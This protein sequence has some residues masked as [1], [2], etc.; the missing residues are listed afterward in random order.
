VR[1]AALPLLRE[2]TGTAARRILDVGTGVGTLLPD[3]RAAF[4]HAFIAGVDRSRGMLALA[5]AVFPRAV[6]DAT[7]LAIP[8][9]SVDLVLLVFMLFHLESPLEA[10][11]EARR[12]VRSGGMAG[13]VTWAS[14]LRSTA[15]RIWKACLDAHGAAPADPA[16]QERH[17]PVNTPGKMQALFQRA[18]FSSV[19]AWSEEFAAPIDLEHLIGLITTMGASK[20]RLDSLGP[21]ARLACIADLRRRAQGLVREDF[22]ASGSVVYTVA[23]A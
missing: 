13:A 5:P 15:M 7:Q 10:V 14:E 22:L 19:R 18:G 6:M 11:R 8:P 12:I 9:A 16:T 21:Q 1:I 20:P 4:P 17:E 23:S 3:L 2:I